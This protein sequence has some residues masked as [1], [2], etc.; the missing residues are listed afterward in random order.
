MTKPLLSFI[1][2]EDLY[3]CVTEVLTVAQKAQKEAGQG[4]KKTGL[5]PFS[6]LFDA[7][8]Q[9]IGLQEWLQQEIARKAQ[10]SL[11][12]HIGTFHEN[13]ISSIPSWAKHG[14]VFDLISHNQKRIAEVKNKYNTTKGNHKRDIYDDLASQIAVY[15]PVYTAYYVEV[16]PPP[17]KR[18][19]K[20]FTP[21]DNRNQTNR[22][23]NPQIRCIDGYSFYALITGEQH[24]LRQLYETLPRVMADIQG[25]GELVGDEFLGKLFGQ[26]YG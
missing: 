17:R 24:A 1:A 11:Q 5:D 8:A 15:Y 23:P 14:G 18:Y 10:K 16:L 12:N 22:P 2:D 20:L 26:V 19:D 13:I 3:R 6:A 25:R 9:G 21:P 4:L 7:Q